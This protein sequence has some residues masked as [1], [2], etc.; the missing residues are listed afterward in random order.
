MKL[1]D[2]LSYEP[3]NGLKARMGIARD[4]LGDFSVNMGGNRLTLSELDDLISGEGIAV[5]FGDI[6]VLED[7]TLA[8]KDSRVLLYIR[9]VNVMSSRW[10]ASEPRYHLSNCSTLI[11]MRENKRFERYHIAAETTGNFILNSISSNGSVRA[12]KRKLAV[13]KN[14]LSGLALDGYHSG[15]HSV[16]KDQYVKNFTPERFFEK[17][18]RS[19][20]TQLPGNYASTAPI[21]VYS[22]DWSTISSRAREEADWK[23]ERCGKEFDKQRRFLL[24]VHHK[25]GLRNDNSSENLAVLCADC[26]AKEPAHGHMRNVSWE[27]PRQYRKTKRRRW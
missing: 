1:P 8:Y 14:C 3:L 5:S 4:Q 10:A 21:N 22:P 9:D 7:G 11:E 20:Y 19:L 12:E 6:T 24:H 17:F 15:M 27:K 2:F 23:C 26:H 18:P 25:N 13:C 16:D